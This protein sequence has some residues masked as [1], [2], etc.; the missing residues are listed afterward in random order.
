MT[1]PAERTRAVL[2]AR[3][4]MYELLDP[5][6]TPKVPKAIRA[7]ALRVLRHYPSP[8]DMERVSMGD[9]FLFGQVDS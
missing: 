9:G 3:Q 5:K 6:C 2:A 7:R 4:F 8:L 1:I